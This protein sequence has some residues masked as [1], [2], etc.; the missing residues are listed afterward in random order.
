M[1]TSVPRKAAGLAALLYDHALTIGDEIRLIWAA[2]RS[3]LKWIFLINHYLSEVGLI[4][5]FVCAN[6]ECALSPYLFTR[7]ST[8]D[9]K[10]YRDSTT[11]RMTTKWVSRQDTLLLG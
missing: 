7:C 8:L 6:G 10:K 5:S 11:F 2:P 3:F 1:L 4:V 9:F